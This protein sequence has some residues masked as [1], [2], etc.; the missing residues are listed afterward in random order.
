MTF[1]ATLFF[2]RLSKKF[3]E[4][5][6]IEFFIQFGGQSS[7]KVDWKHSNSLKFFFFVLKQQLHRH[8]WIS[9]GNQLFAEKNAHYHKHENVRKVNAVRRVKVCYRDTSLSTSVHTDGGIKWTI[10]LINTWFIAFVT[11]QHLSTD[12]R[13]GKVFFNH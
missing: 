10:I 7:L 9:R 4:R 6:Q 13:S 2:I 11:L 5:A 12:L 8:I 1:L 3:H